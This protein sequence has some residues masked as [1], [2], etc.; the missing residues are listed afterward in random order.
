MLAAK[1]TEKDGETVNPSRKKTVNFDSVKHGLFTS[2]TQ[3][4]SVPSVDTVTSDFGNDVETYSDESGSVRVSRVRGMC[5]CMT[6]DLQQNLD[7]MKEYEQDYSRADVHTDVQP[8]CTR[9]ISSAKGIP[10][11]NDSHNVSASNEG[12]SRIASRKTGTLTQE[13]DHF[14]DDLSVQGSKAM[15]EISFLE[16][17]GRMK[18]TDDSCI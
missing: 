8:K 17:D 7:L 18:D 4:P 15:I 14:S 16:D 1:S 3:S 10:G 5:I 6:R 13:D 11:T 12:I 9:E 2:Q